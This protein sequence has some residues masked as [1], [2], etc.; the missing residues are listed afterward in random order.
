MNTLNLAND[1]DA[2]LLVLSKSRLAVPKALNQ[3]IETRG[4]TL[5]AAAMAIG[6]DKGILSAIVNGIRTPTDP[7]IAKIRAWALAKYVPEPQGAA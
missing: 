3:L 7:Q 5:T 1:L 2:H 6:V 4:L